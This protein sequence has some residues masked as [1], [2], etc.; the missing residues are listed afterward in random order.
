MINQKRV[1]SGLEGLDKVLDNIRYGDNI[2]WQI[3]SIE[4]YAFFTRPF[5]EESIRNQKNTIYF[6]FGNGTP[7]FGPMNGISIV[8]ID[9]REGFEATVMQVHDVIERAGVETHYIFDP[10]TMLQAEWVADFMM[11]NFFDVIAPDIVKYKCAAYHAI[12]RNLHSVEAVARIRDG[13]QILL[14]VFHEQD[15]MYLHPLRVTERYGFSMFLPHNVNLHD[16]NVIEPLT[17]GI[18]VSKFYSTVG[19]SGNVDSEQRLDSWERFFLDKQ[20]EM[21]KAGAGPEGADAVLTNGI[22]DLCRLVFGTDERMLDIASKNVNLKDILAIKARMIGVG[23][24]GGKATGM[25]LSRMIVDKRLPEI[26]KLLEPHDS[27]YICSNLYYTFLV[28]NR[29]WG[30]KLK[31]RTKRGYFT[32][33]EIL[34]EKIMEG[35]FTENIREQFRRMLEYYGQSPIIVRSSSLLE[36]SF[37]NAFAGKYE[38]VFCVNLGTLEERLI[39]FE[40]AVRTVYASTMDESVLEYRQ[41]RNLSDKDE[42]MALLVQRVSGSL[43]KDVYMPAAAGVAYSYNSYRWN[44]DI[45]PKQG[46]IRI[47]MGLGTRAVDRTD[48]DYPRI[49]ALDKPDL[50]PTSS[51]DISKYAQHKVDVLELP[52][53]SVATISI[54]QAQ[55]KMSD[56]FRAVMIEHDHSRERELREIGLNRRIVFTTCDSLLRREDFV[57]TMRKILTEIE[58]EYNYPVDIEFTLNFSKDGEFVINL[59][60][61]RPLQVGGSGIRAEAPHIRREKTY[62]LLNGGTMGGSYYQPIDIVV[63]VDPKNYYEYPY[64]KKS[65]VARLIGAINQYYKG[66]EKV[67]MLLVPGRL[68]TTSPE[69]GV[70]VKF[71][72][73]SGVSI[74]GEVAYEG[75]GYMPELSFGSHFFQDLVETD[76]LYVS[77]FENKNTTVHYNPEFLNNEPNILSEILHSDPEAEELADIVKVNDTSGRGL[78][79][80]T[81]ITTGMTLCG[82]F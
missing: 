34:K 56:W 42:Q 39:A 3:S 64:H 67:I 46:M 37:G 48:G 17:N 79:I 80:V 33:A 81:D 19:E 72:E 5:A 13:A 10:L 21:K 26:A 52:T 11:S 75:A 71:A 73:I 32:V 43:F 25:I 82:D 22:R 4:E 65:A 9:P 59:L 1:P 28:K 51:A 41:R 60:Q 70:P 7:V 77:I 45:D 8:P 69:L 40:D 2:V 50:R 14:D 55:E 23:S 63:R 29:C 57:G 44:K 58:K 18:A 78:K 35:E 20:R 27:F 74:A 62:F 30:L 61:C 16:P 54:E 49:A 47:V 6:H 31:Q 68:G 24:V 15:Q 38:S 12:I 76:V 36:D 66:K 53:N